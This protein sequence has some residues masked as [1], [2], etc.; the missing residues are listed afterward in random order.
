MDAT[1]ITFTQEELQNETWKQISGYE[2]TYSVSN[3]GRVRRDLVSEKLSKT[4]CLKPSF[5]GF[6]YPQVTLSKSGTATS[7]SIH[8]LVAQDFISER[9]KGLV[10]GHKD[11][12]PINNR[13]SNLEYITQEENIH[14]S[15]RAGRMALGDRNARRKYPEINKRGEE[16][17]ASV[18]TVEE[19]KRIRLLHNG[20]LQIRPLA[21]I[22]KVNRNTIKN[23][24]NRIT[25]QLVK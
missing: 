12:N 3:L 15:M 24:V 11:H 5:H 23:I 7:R 6:G 20:G 10:V 19:V 25:W 17:H 8:S 16:N 1:N 22:F 14:Q 2:G 21:R 4:I 13:A 9:P 18:L